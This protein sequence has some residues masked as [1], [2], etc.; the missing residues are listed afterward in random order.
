MMKSIYFAGGGTER[1]LSATKP[2]DRSNYETNSG[3][4]QRAPTKNEANPLAHGL[5]RTN[6]PPAERTQQLRRQTKSALPS[7][8]G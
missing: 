7:A 8:P 2:L 6:S 4:F 3:D 5:G 1:T